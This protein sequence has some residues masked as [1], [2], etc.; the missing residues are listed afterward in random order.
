MKILV[1]E[2]EN[3][4]ADYV[5]QGLMEAGFMVDLARN[6]LDGHHMAMNESYD[7]VLLDVMLPDVDGWRIVKSL[8]EAG[9]QMPVLFLTA[10]GGVDDRVKGLELGA[11]DY[12][13]KPFA[14]SELLARVRTLLRRGSAPSQSERLEVADLILDLPRRKATRM[15]QKIVL[16]NKE[17][18]LLELLARRQGE[19][20]PRSLIASQVWDMNFDSDS[21]AIDVAIR[22]L[23]A[24]I[25]D[26]FE[27][28]LIHTVRGMGYT[29]DTPNGK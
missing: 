4:T 19:V 25:D 5:R 24:K 2:D 12:L 21:N 8:R 28:K 22:R 17:F 9:K 6:G 11:D 26:P 10:R 7:L 29:L 23:R 13:I 15:G 14:F 1:V 3:K 27:P 16:T 20:L 18:A